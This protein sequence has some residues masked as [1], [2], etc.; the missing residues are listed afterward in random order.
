MENLFENLAES[1]SEECFEDIMSMVEE[2]LNNEDGA[3]PVKKERKNNKQRL[4]MRQDD[5]GKNKINVKKYY[6][7][8]IHNDTADKDPYYNYVKIKG[9]TYRVGGHYGNEIQEPTQAHGHFPI[10]KK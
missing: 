3:E 5:P 4:Y 1:V 7:R 6:N 2:L 9:E 8:V 10:R